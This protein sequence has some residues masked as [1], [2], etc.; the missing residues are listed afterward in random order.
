MMGVSAIATELL[1]DKYS[2]LSKA[3]TIDEVVNVTRAYLASCTR[4]D[5][6]RLPASCRPG[7]VLDSRDIEEW[8]DRLTSESQRA[9]LVIKDERMLD[10]LTNHFLIASVRIRQLSSV[11]A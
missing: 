11:A 6:E 4:E 8:A 10:R 3:M 9:M 2:E 1:L 7:R 5:L